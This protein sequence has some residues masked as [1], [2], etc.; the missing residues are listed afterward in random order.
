MKVRNG[1]LY[2]GNTCKQIFSVNYGV[3]DYLS[4]EEARENI[5]RL[6]NPIR[7]TYVKDKT[8]ANEREL[9]ISLFANGMV[10]FAWLTAP[11]WNFL[12]GSNSALIFGRPWSME[13]SQ[14]FFP[15]PDVTLT[16]SA[17]NLPSS[18]LRRRIATA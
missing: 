6:P 3:V 10:H 16:S 2:R 1:L 12:L 18:A 7:Y 8:Y 4:W 5:E 17:M 9:R 14:R 13:R 11:K 15:V